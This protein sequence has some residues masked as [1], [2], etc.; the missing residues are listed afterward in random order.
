VLVTLFRLAVAARVPLT[1]DE[2]YYWTW[3]LHPGFGYLDHPP[4]VAWLIGA[5]S[6][7]GHTPLAIRLLFVLCEGA[8]ALVAGAAATALSRDRRAGAAACIAFLL[9]P[10][11]RFVIGE[12]LPDPPFLFFWALALYASALLARKSQG[13]PDSVEGRESVS[14]VILGVALG[15]ALLSRFFGWAIFGGIFLWSLAPGRRALWRRGLWI[16]FAIALFMYVPFLLWDAAHGWQN[17]RFTLGGRTY[18]GDPAATLRFLVFAAAFTAVAYVTTIRA[19]LPLLA[20][21]ALPFPLALAVLSLHEKV[22]TYWLLGPLAS[23]CV[24]AGIALAQP[25]PAFWIRA[26]RWPYV[27]AA[28][29]VAALGVL[30][31]RPQWARLAGYAGVYAYAPLAAQVERDARRLHA[32]VLAERYEVQS[33]LRY[34]GIPTMLVGNDLQVRQWRHWHPNAAAP[35]RAL[36]VLPVTSGDAEITRLLRRAYA[37]VGRVR[38]RVI[39]VDGRP[40]AA[41]DEIEWFGLKLHAATAL[42]PN[43]R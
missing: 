28:A 10:Q 36:L 41:F 31:M 16:A 2:A 1:E 39:V 34:H 12:A 40:I 17:L 15:G 21:T 7:L 43:S 23:L 11:I 26:L 32:G 6:F 30:T 18:A 4:M 5:T 33:E 38:R 20:W 19:R 24:A 42:F 35:E 37:N 8:A 3:S 27:A 22:E 13:D 25:R 29:F 14:T 9:I